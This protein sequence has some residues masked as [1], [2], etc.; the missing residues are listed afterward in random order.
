MELR[1]AS[2]AALATLRAELSAAVDGGAD[3]ATL[4]EELF[5]VAQALRADPP[6]LQAA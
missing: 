1:G 6:V 2:Q 3:A 5:T 4:G